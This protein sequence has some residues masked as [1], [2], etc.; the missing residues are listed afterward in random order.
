MTTPAELAALDAELHEALAEMQQ[1]TDAL[2]AESAALL[3]GIE[4]ER[5]QL[6]AAREQAPEEYAEQA[7]EGGAGRAR[8]ELQRRIDGEETTWREV[9][10]GEDPHWSAVEVRTE[11]AGDARAEVDLIEQ[12]DPDLA[13]TYRT[14][15]TLREGGRIGEWHR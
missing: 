7:R 12:S 3:A 2:R 5:A 11:I 14:H 10:S 1:A 13:R 4:V 9:L 8:Q 15:A 6:R